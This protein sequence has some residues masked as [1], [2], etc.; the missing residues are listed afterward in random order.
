MNPLNVF[1]FLIF[2]VLLGTASLALGAEIPNT[3]SIADEQTDNLYVFVFKEGVA[4]QDIL[5]KVGET[6]KLTNSFGLANF[7]MPADRYEIGYYKDDELFALTEV[8]LAN[9]LNSQIF[10]NL[11]RDSAVV[12]LDLPL[13]DYRKSF[14]QAEIKEQSGPKGTLLLT[15]RDQTSNAA[16][17]NARLY[18]RGYSVEAETNENGVAELELS[19]GPYDI[20][21]VHPK[22]VMQVVKDITVKA[23]Q[24]LEATVAL[25]QSDIVLDEYVVMAP[26]VEGSLAATFNEI[27]DSDVLTDAIS[28]EEFS[29]SGDSSAS[30]ALQR[31][32][33]ITIVD[34][35]FVF[36]RGLGE[37]YS[38]L[39]LN[40][41]VLPSPEP[42]K[43]VVP[44]DIFPTDVIQS[45]DIQKTYSGNLPGTFA[46]GSVQINTK[47]IPEEDNF[48]KGSI[49]LSING[50]LG[51]NVIYNPDNAN[52]VPNILIR[53][54]DG[55]SPLTNE[56]RLGDEILAP[57]ISQDE[58]QALDRA[59]VTYRQFAL[60]R[61]KI[62]PGKSIA[63]GTGQSFKTAGGLKYGLAGNIYYKTE[64]NNT[65]VKQDE[66][67]FNPTTNEVT[68]RESSDK[69]V[70]SLSEKLG[71][72]ISLGVET[73]NQQKFKY[74]FLNLNDS[75]NLTRFSDKRLI[76]EN[77]V[78]EQVFLQYVEKVLISHQLNGVH[79]I[80]KDKGGLFDN[81]DISWGASVSEATRFEPARF[82]YE[83][84]VRGDELEYDEKS[85]F[86]LY[87]DLKDEVENYR[88]DISLP[89]KINDVENRIT[90]GMFQLD[91]TRDL[92]NRRFKVEYANTQD[93]RPIEEVL[94]VENAQTSTLDILDAYRPDDFYTAQRQEFAVYLDILAAP[95]DNLKFNFGARKETAEQSLKVGSSQEEF[96]LD[97]DDVLPF[98]N[99]TYKIN[100]SHQVRLGYSQTLSR[101]DFREFS[102]NRFKDPLTDNI[103][104]GFPGLKATEI[105]NLDLKY[106]W[107]TG[108]DEFYSFGVFTK[109]FTNPIETVRERQDKEIQESFRNADSASSFGFELGFRSKL[110]PLWDALENYF[111]SGNYAW[112]DSEITLSKEVQRDL[113]LTSTNRP[114]QGQSPYVFN[115]KFGYDNFFTRRSAMFL[116]N[117]FGERISAIGIEG[118]PDVYEQPFERLDFVV[119]WGLND[120]HDVQVKKIGYTISFKAKNLLDTERVETQGNKTVRVERPGRSYSLSFSMKY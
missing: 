64:E 63:F 53:L 13:A 79:P 85:A 10:L 49:G 60:E 9:E 73:L 117:V 18:F 108:Y 3:E 4:Q 20:S 118:N 97:T 93:L 17:P 69:Q 42:S 48:I 96:K 109:D 38:N 57:G 29:K 88:L 112:I 105:S 46:G 92:D 86:F 14:E 94:S 21:V 39:L 6:A 80:G 47:D 2:A 36:V 35:K 68:L 54:S 116:F 83:Y 75:E 65:E 41:L 43:R 12:E 77:Q 100:D 25:L 111:V 95:T 115:L 32:T 27:R 7:D 72:L 113:L 119:K 31:V 24:S 11:T 114:M 58:R 107:F 90:L 84:F 59:M 89:F 74:T 67:E 76:D 44:L 23:N 56:V 62:E 78:K 26:V 87:S 71:G 104:L 110:D 50:D 52:D 15:V 40:G 45:M 28:N 5:I 70:T 91:K 99:T 22:Y 61:K 34:D 120:T 33:G 81:L 1:K 82:E 30:D 106:E 8:D 55:F 66:Y 16:V 19:A 98:I 101:P 51:D 103:V 37:R 102:P